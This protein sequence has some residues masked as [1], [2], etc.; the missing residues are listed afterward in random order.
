L[1]TFSLFCHPLQVLEQALADAGLKT[2]DV[3]WLVMHQANQRILDAAAERI[4]LPPARVVSNLSEYGNT[5][6]A[7]IPL[8]LDAA[9]RD[10]RVQP[11][12]VVRCM[13]P[14]LWVLTLLQ[15]CCTLKQKPVAKGPTCLT[16]LHSYAVNMQCPGLTLQ[17]LN[18]ARCCGGG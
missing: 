6:A 17:W 3:D 10:G 11:G 5:S 13:P 1:S 16:V 15:A 18:A 9:V 4:G 8:A 14:R 7:S 2:S 12:D